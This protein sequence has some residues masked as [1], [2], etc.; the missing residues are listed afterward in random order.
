MGRWELGSGGLDFFGSYVCVYV[1][2]RRRKY[3]LGGFRFG[4]RFGLDV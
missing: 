3:G 4:F 2:G 1:Q